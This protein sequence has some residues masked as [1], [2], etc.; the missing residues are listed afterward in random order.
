MGAREIAHQEDEDNSTPE[1]SY[2]KEG[3][4]VVKYRSQGYNITATVLNHPSE[5]AI[6]A[7]NKVY[8]ELF[9]KFN[10]QD[11]V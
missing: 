8:N 4:K 3:Q 11:L 1:I 7:A 10:P 5:E 9:Y 2:N 6:K